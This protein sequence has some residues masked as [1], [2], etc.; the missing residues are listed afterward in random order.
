MK[1]L[2][3]RLEE[4]IVAFNKDGNPIK[5]EKLVYWVFNAVLTEIIKHPDLEIF[6]VGK[7]EIT[8]P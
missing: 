8:L 3:E 6:L 1:E 5:G 2:S 7:E 4:S